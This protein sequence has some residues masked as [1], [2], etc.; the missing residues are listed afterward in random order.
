[1]LNCW[2]SRFQA[3]DPFE[4]I[5]GEGDMPPL[6]TNYREESNELRVIAARLLHKKA[7][8]E[9]PNRIPKALA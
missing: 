7:A 2:I 5:P 1:M 4:K 8:G 6:M 9:T 3:E